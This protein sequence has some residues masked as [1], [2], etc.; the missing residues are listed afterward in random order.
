MFELSIWWRLFIF[1]FAWVLGFWFLL[2][3]L[4]VIYWV[5][6]QDW[7]ERRFG[8]GG[9]YSAI[10]LFGIAFIIIGVAFLFGF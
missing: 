10:K 2:K 1:I 9:T 3:P 4:Q 5:G 6:E 8:P 7:A